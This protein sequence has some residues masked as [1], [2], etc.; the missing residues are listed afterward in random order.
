MDTGFDLSHNSLN[1]IN[2]ISQWDVI[3]DDNQ[4]AD[5]NETESDINQDSHGTMVLSTIASF[6]PN[7]F[8]GVAYDA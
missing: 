4:T 7:E 2:V 3:N 5:E 6:A 1:H 8:M